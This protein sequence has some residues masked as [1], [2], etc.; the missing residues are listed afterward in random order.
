MSIKDKVLKWLEDEIKSKENNI[1]Q[2]KRKYKLVLNDEI[3][4]RYV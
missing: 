4:L 1:E 3:D 2:T